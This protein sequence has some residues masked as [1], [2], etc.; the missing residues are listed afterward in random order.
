MPLQVETFLAGTI[1]AVASNFILIGT[2][3]GDIVAGRAGCSGRTG[4]AGVQ[5]VVGVQ[6]DSVERGVVH[7][8]SVH[9]SQAQPRS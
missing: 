6:G 8:A 2:P 9:A 7:H 1:F 3:G 5:G 4:M